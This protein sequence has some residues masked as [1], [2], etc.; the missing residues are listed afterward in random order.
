MRSTWT[1]RGWF[2]R[3]GRRLSR[4]CVLPEPAVGNPWPQP[5]EH[6]PCSRP[7]YSTATAATH[8][9][10]ACLR[11][12]LRVQAELLSE[13]QAPK[14]AEQI[15]PRRD[16][17]KVPMFNR[18]HAPRAHAHAAAPRCVAPTGQCAAALGFFRRGP[19]GLGCTCFPRRCHVSA[20]AAADHRPTPTETSEWTVTGF[21][22]D[23]RASGRAWHRSALAGRGAEDHRPLVVRRNG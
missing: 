9:R 8:R 16:K 2:W 15:N 23:G 14:G 4:R 6:A 22:C 19:P 10:A 13:W 17:D 5:A 3:R 1:R 11:L 20:S 21:L 18:T 12:R 7:Q